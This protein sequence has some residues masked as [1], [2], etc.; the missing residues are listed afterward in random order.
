M[1]SWYLRRGF[2]DFIAFGKFFVA[3]PVKI[4]LP[5]A[6]W[7]HIEPKP[8]IEAIP[9]VP[10]K[11]VMVCPRAAVPKDERNWRNTTFYDIQVW[12]YTIVSP[13]QPGLP[14]VDA[15]PQVA[16]KRAYNG[17]RRT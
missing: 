17:V 16:L 9:E 3:R 13:M 5:P 10:L 12:L 14:P 11:N 15:D 7:N 4:E 1:L 8:M 2:W 6:K